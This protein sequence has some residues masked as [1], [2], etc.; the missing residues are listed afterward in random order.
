VVINEGPA[1]K[2]YRICEWCG[3]GTPAASRKTTEHEHLLTRA[4]C[5]GP[6]R[7]TSLAHSYQ[8]DFVE[9]RFDP[10]VTLRATPAMLRSAVYALLE[11][12]ALA[13]ENSRDDVDRTVYQDPDGVPALV[14][15]DTT[16]GG[17]GNALRIAGHLAE[18][19]AAAVDRVA[20][21]ECGPETSCYGCLRAYRNQ[22]YH[23]E[24]SR[25]AALDLL[26]ELVPQGQP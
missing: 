15:F 21:C 2:G 11:G 4:S 16:P 18:V 22:R 12:A 24:L 19:V 5:T 26:G 10:V 7:V 3:A 14:L 8:T 6:M 1:R 25:Q 23:E 20:A 17:A 9:L 13:L